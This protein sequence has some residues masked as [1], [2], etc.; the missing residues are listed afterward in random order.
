[1]VSSRLVWS[2][3]ADWGQSALRLAGA[4]GS[5]RCGAAQADAR[6]EGL[7]RPLVAVLKDQHVQ[8][9]G[10]GLGNETRC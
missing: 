3:A 7:A 6:P 10:K 2:R 4:N 1:M 8:G 9:A 5:S